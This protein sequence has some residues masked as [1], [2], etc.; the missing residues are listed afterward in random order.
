M[1]VLAQFYGSEATAVYNG[2]TFSSLPLIDKDE[3][4]VEWRLFKQALIQEFR[5]VRE[6]KQWKVQVLEVFKDKN[7]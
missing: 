2:V 3:I 6:E 1:E 4:L 5:L 7:R